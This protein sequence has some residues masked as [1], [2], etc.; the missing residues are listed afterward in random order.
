LWNLTKGKVHATDPSNV[1]ATGM[2]DPWAMCWSPLLGFL[3]EFPPKNILPEVRPTCSDFGT[4][5][6]EYFGYPIP[7][8]VLMGDQS[9]ALFGQCCF[10]K[11]DVNC[12]MGTGTFVLV[13]TGPKC[14]ASHYGMYPTIGWQIGNKITYTLEGTSGATGPVIDWAKNMGFV[15]HVE[16]LDQCAT[17][18]SD[19]NDLY[20]VPAFSGIEQPNF[21]HHARGLAI[22]ITYSTSKEHFVRAILEGI[23]FRVNDIVQPVSRDTGVP[24]KRIRVCG[25]VSKNSFICQFI[26][27]I[28][29]AEVDRPEELETTSLGVAYLAGLYQG[30]FRDFKHLT[31]L[32]KSDKVFKPNMNADVR[33]VK[34]NEVE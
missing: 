2:W 21:D 16:E 33:Q 18:L 7:V 31:E 5:D 19:T 10:E 8:N 29:N 1:I 13:N 24:I 22:G 17:Q 28:T 4:C 23:S 15:N 3:T 34:K 25:G 26:S 27:D 6:P 12:T 9:A 11:G 14:L 32:R 20:F 30:V